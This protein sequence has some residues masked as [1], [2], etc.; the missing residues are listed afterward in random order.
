MM[1]VGS[2]A[3][4]ETFGWPDWIVDGGSFG[5]NACM[6]FVAPSCSKS[7]SIDFN[8]CV[9]LNRSIGCRLADVGVAFGFAVLC[10]AVQSLCAG[11]CW[12]VFVSLVCSVCE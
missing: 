8:R 4:G 10:G 11:F 12:R 6:H 1:V 9:Q 3:G 7:S 5:L 2:L